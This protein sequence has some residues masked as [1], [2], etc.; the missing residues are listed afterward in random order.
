[1]GIPVF[2]LSLHKSQRQGWLIS[3]HGGA[4]RQTLREGFTIK[5]ELLLAETTHHPAFQILVSTHFTYNYVPLERPPTTKKDI[6]THLTAIVVILLLSQG[7]ESLN[8][9]GD[10]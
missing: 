5:A 8:P 7:T 10:P 6:Q 3:G 1:M 2:P 4:W 9:T